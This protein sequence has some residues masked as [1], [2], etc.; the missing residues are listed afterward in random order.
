MK[1]TVH[2]IRG[3]IVHDVLEKFYDIDSSKLTNVNYKKLLHEHI[4]QLFKHEWADQVHKMKNIGISQTEID[5]YHDDSVMQIDKWLHKFLSQIDNKIKD[6]FLIKNAWQYYFPK[7]REL[8]LTSDRYGTLGYLDQV[9]ELGDRHLVLD[10]K[11]GSSPKLSNE[12]MLQLSTYYIMY[13]EK[14]S[15]QPDTY[16]WFLKF[17][18]KKVNI[19]PGLL[20]DTKFKIEQVHNAMKSDNIL[21]YPKNT[22]P[23]C[24]WCNANGAG[25]CDFY[26]VCC[27]QTI[28]AEK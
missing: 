12:Y 1:D 24:K 10:F 17:G 3:N 6:V 20:I 25:Q 21:D 15:V 8:K 18:L 19:T 2:T 26:D 11:T 13:E 9:L 16:L 23:L 22:T 28:L 4:S 5:F 14:Y 7:Y 27:G